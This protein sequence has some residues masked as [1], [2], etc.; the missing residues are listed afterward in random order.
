MKADNRGEGGIFS[1]FSLVKSYA[2]WLL[3]P[4]MIGGATLL[5]DSILTPAVTVTT[6]IEGLISLPVIDGTI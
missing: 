5:A 4:A 6:A 1:L 2:K 3:I